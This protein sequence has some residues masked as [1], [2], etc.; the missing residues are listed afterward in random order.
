MHGSSELGD[1][2]GDFC[3]R[4]LRILR[5]EKLADLVG[6]LDQLA[7]AVRGFVGRGHWRFAFE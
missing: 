6:H 3:R 4:R 2:L 1:V 5:F 7:V